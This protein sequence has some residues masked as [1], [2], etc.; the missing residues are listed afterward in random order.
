MYQAHCPFLVISATTNLIS[1]ASASSGSNHHAQY[2]PRGTGLSTA[3]YKAQHAENSG[4]LQYQ[5]GCWDCRGK[6][7]IH[8]Q[9]CRSKPGGSSVPSKWQ[10]RRFASLP[11]P[12]VVCYDGWSTR[13][14]TVHRCCR[15]FPTAGCRVSVV[16][17]SRISLTLSMDSE[18]H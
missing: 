14:E 12:S 8:S 7:N 9:H 16:K 10:F 11:L 4:F 17:T 3:A 13:L 15:A 5:R 2:F 18:I 1:I 6:T